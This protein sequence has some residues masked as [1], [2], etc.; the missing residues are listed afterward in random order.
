M[1]TKNTDRMDAE[2]RQRAADHELYMLESDLEN[3]VIAG[4]RKRQKAIPGLRTDKY[5]RI[6]IWGDGE[7]TPGCGACCL[8]G[9]WTQIRTTTKCCCH[10]S[11]CYHFTGKKWWGVELIPPDMYVINDTM[12]SENDVRLLFENQG[13][14]F[15]N[16]VAWLHFEPLMELDKMLPLM[17]FIKGKGLHQWLYTNGVLATEVTLKKMRD[18]GLDEIRFNLA[19][20]NCADPVIKNMKRAR[21]FFK[22]LCVESPVFTSFHNS[23]MKKRSAILDTGVDHINFAELQLFPGTL[24]NFK[25]EGQIYRYRKGY[26]SPVKSRQ[27]VY[28]I[29]E[30]ASRERWRGVVLHDCSNETKFLRGIMAMSRVNMGFGRI[31][32]SSHLRLE[33]DHYEKMIEYLNISDSERKAKLKKILSDNEGAYIERF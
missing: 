14:N 15:V 13:G 27:L 11:F 16:G 25:N 7:L 9:R 23:F 20:T 18:A 6:A 30:T 32:Y 22:Y 28:D 5:G 2:Y 8:E 19:A 31:S 21:K 26:V 17:K 10:C 3:K 4:I 12:Y 24:D 29:F 33:K 1:K